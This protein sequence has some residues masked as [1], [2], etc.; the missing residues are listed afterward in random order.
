MRSHTR[1]LVPLLLAAVA[2]LAGGCGDDDDGGDGG[3]QG[4]APAQTKVRYATSFGLFGRD[5]Y[6]FVAKEKGFF[7]EA[8]FDVEIVPGQGSAEVAKLIGAGRL[9][10]GPL[11]FNALVVARAREGV[12]VKI[13]SFVHQNAL[14]AV[15]A[16]GDSGIASPKDLEGKT[17]A[18]SAGSTVRIMFPLYAERAGIDADAVK[19]RPADPSSLPSL[20]AAKQVDAVGQFVV[21]EPLFE[22]VTRAKVATLPYS[23]FLPD[24]PGLGIGVSDDKLRIDPDEVRRFVA[25]LNKGLQ[26]A[27]DHP[28]EAAEILKANAPEG[29]AEIAAQ[30]L[31]VM[32]DYVLNDYTAKHGIGAIDEKRLTSA[33]DDIAETFD[34]ADPPAVEDVYASGF[35]GRAAGG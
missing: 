9:D 23:E 1:R 16:R 26:Y 7:E 17:I 24:L 22:K 14:N 4:D 3:A 25:A 6:A 8:G 35:T 5:A 29:D 11:D 20:L 10:Y 13:A 12:P 19:F 18:D 28:D 30:E 21:G 27:L 34:V 31:V 2:L 15:I 33:I 32:R